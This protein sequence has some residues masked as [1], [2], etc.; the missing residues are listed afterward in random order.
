M[1]QVTLTVNNQ[2]VTIDGEV[3]TLSYILSNLN[4]SAPDQQT[5]KVVEEDPIKF[6]DFFKSELESN[7]KGGKLFVSELERLYHQ[8]KGYRAMIRLYHDL[9]NKGTTGWAK[10]RQL[11]LTTS[12]IWRYVFKTNAAKSKLRYQIEAITECEDCG[13]FATAMVRKMKKEKLWV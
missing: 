5:V 13:E 2:S 12:A 7:I 9:V 10:R 11:L 3:A 8:G 1:A 4:Y 6:V